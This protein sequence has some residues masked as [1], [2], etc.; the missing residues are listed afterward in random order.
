SIVSDLLYHGIL[1]T[2][3]LVVAVGLYL[4]EVAR[5]CR[6]GVWLP[7]LTFVILVNTFEGL[8]GKTT[9]LAKFVLMLIVLFPIRTGR[10]R[11]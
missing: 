4:A 7:I 8:A 10:A 1:V 3:L 11:T 5:T 2:A 6:R 9:M